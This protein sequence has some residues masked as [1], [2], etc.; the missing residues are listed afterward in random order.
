MKDF[1]HDFSH[2]IDLRKSPLR[3]KAE[4]TEEYSV[5]LSTSVFSQWNIHIPLCFYKGT[6][7]DRI[8]PP[9]SRHAPYKTCVRIFNLN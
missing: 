9:S 6:R 5:L 7:A 2:G 1:M 4:R 3:G 8:R